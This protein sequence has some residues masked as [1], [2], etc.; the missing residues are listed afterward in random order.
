MKQSNEY[1]LEYMFRYLEKFTGQY[2]VL[3]EFVDDLPRNEEGEI[4][5][6][7][8]DL[9]IPCR[10]GVIKHTYKGP[11][12]LALCFYDKAVAA[13]NTYKEIKD[14]YPDLDIELDLMKLDTYGKKPKEFMSSDGYI[15]FNANDIKK[16]ATIVKPKTSGA[17][18]RWDDPKNLPKVEYVIPGNDIKMY[19]DIINSMDRATK[20]RFGKTVNNKFLESITKKNF[21]AKK[22]LKLS[23]LGPKEYFHSIG[24]WDAFIKL[25]KKT[26]KEF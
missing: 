17:S 10:K 21:D 4:D 6:S 15:Y 18:I 11:D 1:V 22:E 25:A 13:K 12:I 23:R 24:K 5:E 8:E 14:K 26:A 3:P 16:I 19:A 9:Y 7:F 2:R 20:M